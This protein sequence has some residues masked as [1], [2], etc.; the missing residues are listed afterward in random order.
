MSCSVQ[1]AR[2][3]LPGADAL[4]EEIGKRLGHETSCALGQEGEEG[5]GGGGVKERNGGQSFISACMEIMIDSHARCMD[6]SG[7]PLQVMFV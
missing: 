3:C 4:I 1:H 2:A 5:G 7:M 6:S